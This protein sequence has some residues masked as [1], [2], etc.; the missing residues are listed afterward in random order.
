MSKDKGF[1]SHN[2]EL[3]DE[4]LNKSLLADYD[5]YFNTVEKFNAVIC[6]LD[7]LGYK[8]MMIERKLE[9]LSE[10]YL[11]TLDDT[12][13]GCNSIL[14]HQLEKYKR[15]SDFK[16]KV[17]HL[18]WFQFSDTILLYLR[19]DENSTFLNHI[20]KYRLFGMTSYLPILFAHCLQKGIILRGAVAYGEVMINKY[21]SFI[22]GKPI[23]EAYEL[24]KKQKWAG[25]SLCESADQFTKADK[26]EDYEGA[27]GIV[28]YDVPFENEAKNLSVCAWYW[29]HSEEPD[30]DKLFNSDKPDVIRKKENTKK[31]YG[32]HT[33][34]LHYTNKN[35]NA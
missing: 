30:W 34:N 9:D 35:D 31:F 29:Q 20:P 4:A 10:L 33:I 24:E 13:Y 22:V 21:K 11:K 7:I 17:Y 3:M 14:D 27:P 28:K 23:I 15:H 8:D 5:K 6:M 26:F 16:G 18:E 2:M 32:T 25:I 12:V 19:C 1:K